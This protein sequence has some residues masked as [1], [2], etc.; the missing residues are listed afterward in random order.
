MTVNKTRYVYILANERYG[1]LYV[2]VTSDI[3]RRIWEHREGLV[4]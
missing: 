1:T 3:V 2:G 4:K